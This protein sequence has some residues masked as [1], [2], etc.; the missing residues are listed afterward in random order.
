[1]AGRRG[2]GLCWSAGRS[3]KSGWPAR[4]SNRSA[5]GWWP[6]ATWRPSIAV[7]RRA[8]STRSSTRRAGEAAEIFP[9][10]SCHAVYQATDGVPRLVNH[11]CDHV[12]LMAMAAGKS[13]D[14]ARARGGGMGR[15]AAIAD[16]LER[17]GKGGGSPASVVEFGRLEEEPQARG[18]GSG[19]GGQGAVE[20]GA[21]ADE[22]EEAGG[23]GPPATA[24]EAVSPAAPTPETD[25]PQ[26]RSRCPP[27]RR[28]SSSGSKP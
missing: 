4:S 5:N 13:V 21:L 7:R 18:Q 6:D 22:P 1:M 9:P 28:N 20:F 11:V 27:S 19:F 2:R 16:S 3:W 15:L 26:S 8:T 17:R 12:L 25:W 24:A 10:E 23:A 14:A